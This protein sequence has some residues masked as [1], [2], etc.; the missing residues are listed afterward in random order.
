[1]WMMI[2]LAVSINNPKDIPGR[3][4]LDFPSQQTCEVSMQSMSF[5]LKFDG[6]KVTAQCVKKS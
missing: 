5:W 3:V 1:M 2:L 4:T 6:F